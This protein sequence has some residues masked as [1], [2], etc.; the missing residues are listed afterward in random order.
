MDG[1]GDGMLGTR[2]TSS[3]TASRRRPRHGT[4]SFVIVVTV[5]AGIG[6]PSGS[7]H[8]ER[9]SSDVVVS[10]HSN[11]SAKTKPVVAVFGDSL[12]TQ[13]TT[14]LASGLSNAVVEQYSFPGIAACNYLTTVSNYLKT[15]KPR[16]AILE[17]WGN[18]NLETPCMTSPSESPGYYSEYRTDLTMMTK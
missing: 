13:A 3:P 10:G 18:D 16:V 2:Q 14:A 8:A 12:I 11:T 15:H 5:A 6:I 17:F 7:A 9:Q 4:L 1:L